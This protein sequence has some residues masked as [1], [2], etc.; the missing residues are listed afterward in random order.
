MK[1]M[2]PQ[3]ELRFRLGVVCHDEDFECHM[4]HD[5]LVKRRRINPMEHG[6]RRCS[7]LGESKQTD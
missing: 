7:P 2:C 4:R 1:T 6:Y 3:R 5:L